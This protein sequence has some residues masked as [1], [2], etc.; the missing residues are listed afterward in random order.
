[1]FPC[2]QMMRDEHESYYN[3]RHHFKPSQSAVQVFTEG[4]K[5]KKRT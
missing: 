4:M 5:K 2:T 1:M 3:I